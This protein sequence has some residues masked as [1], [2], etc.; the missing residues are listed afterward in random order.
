MAKVT[1]TISDT[2]D[3]VEILICS[4]S[5]NESSTAN[6]L[7]QQIGLW[8]MHSGREEFMNDLS[9]VQQGQAGCH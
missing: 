4:D 9:K 7:G 6:M 2:D 1:I 8:C 5:E 3:G